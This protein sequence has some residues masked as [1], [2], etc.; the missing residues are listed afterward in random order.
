LRFRASGA[1]EGWAAFARLGIGGRGEGGTEFA[2]GEGVEGTEA[3]GELRSGQATL[4]VEFAKEIRSWGCSFV[5][6]AFQAAGHEV[7]VGITA[8]PDLGHNVIQALDASG[9]AAEAVEAKTALARVDGLAE[10]LILEEIDSLQGEGLGAIASGK[11]A[12]SRG[13]SA[14]K[15]GA[16]LLG[17]EDLDIV[18]SLAACEQA[19]CATVEEAADG[20]PSSA[21][22]DANPAG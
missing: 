15:G 9:E 14:W 3:G 20:R 11:E 16:N 6:I 17:Q 18:T 8:Q 22:A 12:A 7:A 2:G 4:A 19:Q 21:L 5:R 10:Q 13:R 1:G